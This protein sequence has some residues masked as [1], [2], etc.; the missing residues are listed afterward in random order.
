MV[1][2]TLYERAIVALLNSGKF[3]SHEIVAL[4]GSLY[5]GFDKDREGLREEIGERF[6][7]EI[8]K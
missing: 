4:S 8:E 3:D 5:Y 1:L 6:M 2:S 7:K